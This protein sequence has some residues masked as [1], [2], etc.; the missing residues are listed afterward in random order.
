MRIGD[1]LFRIEEFLRPETVA[2][3]AGAGGTVERE[4]PRLQFA[5]GIVAD[6]TGEFIGKHQFGSLRCVH[7]RDSRNAGAQTQRGLEGFG[8][9]LTKIGPHFEPVDDGFDGVFAAYLELRG[10][11]QFHYLAVDPGPHEAAGLQFID[12]FG[13]FAFALRNGRG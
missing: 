3:G 2:A 6:G 4:Q 7:V 12:Q 9:T 5:Q 13:V 11:V 1:D 10:L 8:Q